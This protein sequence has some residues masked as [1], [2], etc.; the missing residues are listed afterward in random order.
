MHFALIVLKAFLFAVSN[1]GIGLAVARRLRLEARFVPML[2]IALQ[3]LILYAGALVGLLAP[4]AYLLLVGGAVLL[5]IEL[6]LSPLRIP[7][8][9]SALFEEHGSAVAAVFA[10]CAFA[11]LAKGAIFNW[12]DSYSHWG[13]IVRVMLRDD[14]LPNAYDTVIRFP[15]YPPGTA[16]FVW[17]AARF[18]NQSES[19]QML[20]QYCI[21]LAALLCII[22]SDKSKP[23]Y[24]FI[25]F[26]MLAGLLLIANRPFEQWICFGL[27]VDG[28]LSCVAAAYAVYAWEGIRRSDTADFDIRAFVFGAIVL[29][30]YL[31]LVKH[32]ALAFSIPITAWVLIALRK[33]FD[34]AKPVLLFAS[35]LLSYAAWRIHVGL[36][37]SS[38]TV[39]QATMSLSHWQSIVSEKTPEQIYGPISKLASTALSYP[40]LWIFL[41]ACFFLL[42]IA[43]LSEAAS[44][45]TVRV[46]ALGMLI[47][48]LLWHIGLGAVYTFTMYISESTQMAAYWRYTLSLLLFL[49]LS[50]I[51]W[52][53]SCSDRVER[54]SA[55]RFQVLNCL[56]MLYLAGF[57]LGQFSI[58]S[59]VESFPVRSTFEA[60]KDESGMGEGR[61]IFLVWNDEVRN[62]YRSYIFC[63]YVFVSGDVYPPPWWDISWEEAFQDYAPEENVDYVICLDPENEAFQK[64]VEQYYPEQAG[65][66]LIVLQH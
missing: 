48:L 57:A 56:A 4:V 58:T 55:Y 62:G 38:E 18:V 43:I 21:I 50:C 63:R 8:S 28:L 54:P 13:L 32:S 34:A 23:S 66:Q 39:D 40:T 16:L 53:L 6:K 11:V 35:S 15:D 7:E 59:P 1:L 51:G 47:I 52:Y 19:I 65:Q 61:S 36:A 29:A 12:G 60:I 31:N 9:L 24:S 33:R 20:A 46:I 5:A 30:S 42:L 44:Q 14:A 25:L 17:Y 3:T 64:W 26:L 27:Y 2:S 22:P 49:L 10:L 45:K 41:G 37:F